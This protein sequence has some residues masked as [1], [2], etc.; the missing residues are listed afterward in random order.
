MDIETEWRLAC[1][2]ITGQ[3]LNQQEQQ[4]AKQ[5]QQRYQLNPSLPLQKISH[6]N[7]CLPRFNLAR[8]LQIHTGQ[9][10]SNLQGLELNQFLRKQ[11][12]I[13]LKLAG[14]EW[15]VPASYLKGKGCYE[16]G[17]VAYGPCGIPLAQDPYAIT[18]ADYQQ[19]LDRQRS[20]KKSS[21]KANQNLPATNDN[22]KIDLPPVSL[23]AF[24]N[25]LVF[26]DPLEITNLDLD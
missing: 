26:G 12:Y 25:S 18:L 4:H 3:Q 9:G 21:K 20:E 2:K 23:T 6:L 24:I 14:Q 13:T 15:K 11:K 8:N 5:L 1:K 10:L 7:F 22:E 17:G 16:N 19:L